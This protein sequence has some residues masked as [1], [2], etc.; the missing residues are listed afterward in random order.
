MQPLEDR[1]DRLKRRTVGG[2][3]QPESINSTIRKFTKNCKRYLSEGSALR[4]IYIVVGDAIK[5]WTRP[6]KHWKTALNHFAILFP[7]RTP[8]Q[9]QP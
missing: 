2:A 6:I 3:I 1:G 7:D 5:R 9:H 8:N 4:L